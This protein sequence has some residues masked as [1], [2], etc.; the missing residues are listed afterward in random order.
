MLGKGGISVSQTSIFS[1]C[2]ACEALQH[3]D[4]F[5]RLCFCLCVCPV[6]M[7]RYVSQVT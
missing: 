1:F 4:H 2:V 7:H 6:V 5:V 3:R